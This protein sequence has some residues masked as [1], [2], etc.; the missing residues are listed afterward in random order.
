MRTRAGLKVVKMFSLIELLIVVSVIAI[1][2]SL[3]L[4]ALQKA[5][6]MALTSCC[7]SKLKQTYNAFLSYAG[8][9]NEYLP[10]TYDPGV[11][12][13]WS[14]L[15]LSFGYVSPHV[16][17]ASGKHRHW[18][19]HPPLPA[20]KTYWVHSNY[21]GNANAMG[22]CEAPC[23]RWGEIRKPT[24]TMLVMDADDAGYF[25]RISS[26][27]ASRNPTMHNGGGNLLF[28]DGHTVWLPGKEN[29]TQYFCP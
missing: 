12:K 26:W 20:C 23:H 14:D 22:W 18:Q 21:D 29:K 19:K 1:L 13:V 24:I 15:F 27:T 7:A 5:K 25:V 17:D 8:D 16:K 4:P 6:G 2:A 11:N 10:S 9:F 3:L 28:F